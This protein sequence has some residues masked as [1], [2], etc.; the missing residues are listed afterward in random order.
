MQLAACT[1]CH[2]LR[3]VKDVIAYKEEGKAAVMNCLHKEFPNNPRNHQCNNPLSVLKKNK[4]ATIAVPRMLYPKPSIRQQ[5]SMLY[6]RPG[7]EN[8]LKL[9]GVQREGHNIYSDIYDGEVWKTFP[10]SDGS[11]FFTTETAT[12]HLG[13][14]FNLDWFQPFKYTQHSTGAIYASICNLPRSERNKPENTIY[15]GFLLGPKEVGLKRI[16][17]YLAPIVNEFLEL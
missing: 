15:L 4:Y 8:M 12:T 7:F 14:L 10:S 17:H 9:S 5:L 1:E 6:Q 13:L 3:N 2:K 11:L 16:N